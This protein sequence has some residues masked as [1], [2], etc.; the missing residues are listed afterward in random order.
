MPA[1]AP[2]EAMLQ[3]EPSVPQDGTVPTWLVSATSVTF[4]SEAAAAA[5]HT[6]AAP[7][8]PPLSQPRASTLDVYMSAGMQKAGTVKPPAGTM[9]VCLHVASASPTSIVV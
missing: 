2:T 3:P 4:S 1:H 7:T 6:A 8:A 9:P 5:S